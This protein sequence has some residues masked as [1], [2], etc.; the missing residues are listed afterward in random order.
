[1]ADFQETACV[2]GARLRGQSESR[3]HV[4]DKPCVAHR[5][6]QGDGTVVEARQP[7]WSL[8]YLAD[9]SYSPDTEFSEWSMDIPVRMT[10]ILGFCE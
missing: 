4:I 6:A 9:L 8:T 10:S 3:G 7:S 1:M 2:S 5:N